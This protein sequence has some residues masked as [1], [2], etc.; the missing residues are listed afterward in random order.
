MQPWKLLEA[1]KRTPVLH[2]KYKSAKYSAK[3]KK[4][5]QI[6]LHLKNSANNRPKTNLNFEFKFFFSILDH[7][8]LQ[9]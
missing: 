5:R 2:S 6:A 8:V 9:L 1:L 7:V 4:I 3:K